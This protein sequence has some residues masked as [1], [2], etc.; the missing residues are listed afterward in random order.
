M[1]RI[2]TAGLVLVALTVAAPSALAR[3]ES[4]PIKG[5]FPISGP[6]LA[7]GD[8]V[9]TESTAKRGYV[10]RRRTGSEQRVLKL[11]EPPA[12]SDGVSGSPV[13]DVQI[14]TSPSWIALQRRLIPQSIDRYNE[15]QFEE[16]PVLAA[17]TGGPFR[18]VAAGDQHNQL[19]RGVQ[20]SGSVLLYPQ[21]ENVAEDGV[22]IRDL[23][24]SGPSG[25]V[26]LK[27]VVSYRVAG[28]LV[29]WVN[30]GEIVVYDWK[31]GRRLYT[32]RDPRINGPYAT[33]SLS[34]Q[35]DG[36]LAASFGGEVVW[37]SPT[38]PFLHDLPLRRRGYSYYA[39]LR[40]DRIVYAGG[41]VVDCC[42]IIDRPFL[43]VSDLAGHSRVI[44]EPFTGQFDFDGDRV[45]WLT[46]TCRG[47]RIYQADVHDRGS[48]RAKTCRLALR[49]R[50]VVSRHRRV[51]FRIRCRGFALPCWPQKITIKTARAYRAGRSRV[52]GGAT[53]S[54][55]SRNEGVRLN[56][57]GVRLLRARGRVRAVVTARLTDG[58]S[59]ITARTRVTI[60]RRGHR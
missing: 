58:Y 30:Y 32:V 9:W 57:R 36:K 55:L 37:A 52:P 14:T 31:A 49:R 7:N 40:K 6:A 43:G 44:T 4:F 3:V 19:R 1:N 48:L 22:G 47:V 24:S 33:V 10:L 50:K 34:L 18:Q 39:E 16:L 11:E 25:R 59:Q 26:E 60:H 29:A 38:E 8:V 28:R 35:T 5:R 45:S 15:T 13:F 54:E 12:R 56:P 23:A 51:R 17:H 41:R 46:R 21:G 20:L 2:V 53:L 27:D 42:D